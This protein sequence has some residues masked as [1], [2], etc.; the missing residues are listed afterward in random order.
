MHRPT[1][2]LPSP[3]SRRQGW[4]HA[5]ALLALAALLGS[6]GQVRATTLPVA[7]DELA[8]AI[9]AVQA[10]A[11][12]TATPDRA[13]VCAQPPATSGGGVDLVWSEVTDQEALPP[14]Q[15]RLPVPPA[16]LQ[17]TGQAALQEAEDRPLLRPPIR[18]A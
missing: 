15:M 1:P 2:S 6:W 13:A 18:L 12:V 8:Q 10:Q 7:A 16:L 3:A 14:R 11:E 4:L 5:L 9:V 17:T